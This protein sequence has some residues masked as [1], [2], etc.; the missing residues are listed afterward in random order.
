MTKTKTFNTK[1]Q[2]KWKFVFAISFLILATVLEVSGYGNLRLGQ[3]YF[4]AW[5][6]MVGIIALIIAIKNHFYGGE[7]K[8]DERTQLLML[9]ASKKTFAILIYVAI[10]LMF[11]GTINPMKVDLMTIASVVLFSIIIMYKFFYWRLSKKF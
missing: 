1:E 7:I 2:A 5:L 10:G 9:K 8:Y 3:M 6:Y 11:M 4:S